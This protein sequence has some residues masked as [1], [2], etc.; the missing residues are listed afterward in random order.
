MGRSRIRL[1][2]AVNKPRTGLLHQR[3]TRPPQAPDPASHRRRRHFPLSGLFFGPALLTRYTA[4][5]FFP[6]A[7]LFLVTFFLPDWNKMLQKIQSKYFWL[8]GL[9]GIL[10]ILWRLYALWG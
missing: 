10:I 7:A 8:G 5:L 3:E 2:G 1:L 9:I 4:L 6:I